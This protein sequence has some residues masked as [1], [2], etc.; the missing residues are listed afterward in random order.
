MNEVLL[1]HLSNLLGGFQSLLGSGHPARQCGLGWRWRT[2]LADWG[3]MS[4][5]GGM[6]RPPNATK[7]RI[8]G[9]FAGVIM[10]GKMG[11]CRES[12]CGRV[13]APNVG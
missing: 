11:H 13:G 8:G 12:Q 4:S 3:R 5:G 1:D 2:N 10:G 9:A 7:R 6:E